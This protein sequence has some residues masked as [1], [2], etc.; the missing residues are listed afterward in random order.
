MEA[1]GVDPPFYGTKTKKSTIDRDLYIEALD[2]GIAYL[3]VI[4]TCDEKAN[5]GTELYILRT[6]TSA[7]ISNLKLICETICDFGE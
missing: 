2:D 6:A 4:M 7:C 5:D 3:N 1:L